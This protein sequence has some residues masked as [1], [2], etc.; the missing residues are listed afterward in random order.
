MV[1]TLILQSKCFISVRGSQRGHLRQQLARFP[2]GYEED[3]RNLP[4]KNPEEELFG[5]RVV[6]YYGNAERD[7]C[8]WVVKECQFRHLFH[9][10]YFLLAISEN[11]LHPD[12]ARRHGEIRGHLGGQ[13]VYENS[14]LVVCVLHNICNI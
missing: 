8:E 14:R 6:L 11:L 2:G 10:N 12:P 9:L 5:R 4:D 13:C 1:Y 3:A 7:G